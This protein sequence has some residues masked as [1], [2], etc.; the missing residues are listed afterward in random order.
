MKDFHFASNSVMK[1]NI[2]RFGKKYN[3]N[4]SQT[5][6]NLVKTVSF[7]LDRK[8]YYE[9]EDRNTYSRVYADCDI[10][11][12]ISE[13]EYRKI[14]VIHANMNFYSMAK[15]VRW[16]IDLFFDIEARL[17]N[18]V[19]QYFNMER[20]DFFKR[21]KKSGRIVKQLSLI[22]SK[23]PVMNIAYNDSYQVIG[24]EIKNE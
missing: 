4:I 5:I 23:I 21:L 13:E 12:Y 8:H 19:F 15:L 2:I 22:K 10:H 18:K 17:G 24:V 9:E 20:A 3:Y 11:L 1:N 16:M 14:K 6:R 7:Y